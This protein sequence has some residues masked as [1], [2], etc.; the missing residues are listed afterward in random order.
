MF[1]T[2]TPKEL[3]K[4][5]RSEGGRQSD[6]GIMW[7]RIIYPRTKLATWPEE[8][9]PVII[10]SWCIPKMSKF[11]IDRISICR[12]LLSFRFPKYRNYRFEKFKTQFLIFHLYFLSIF[13]IPIY[14]FTFTF[15]ISISYFHFQLPIYLLPFLI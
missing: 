8:Y 6:E 4:V 14:Q 15:P 9:K 3:L 12:I 1:P 5:K 11:S 13:N 10:L 2:N 7:F